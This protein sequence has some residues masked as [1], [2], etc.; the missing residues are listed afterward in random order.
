MNY[1]QKNFSIAYAEQSCKSGRAFRIGFG[2][3]VDKN[4]GLIRAWDVLFVLGEHKYN[5]NNLA[6]LVNFSDLI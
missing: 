2:P 3:K 4:F 6:T 1:C 5:W